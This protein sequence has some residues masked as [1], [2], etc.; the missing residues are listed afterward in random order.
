MTDASSQPRPPRVFLS[1]SHDSA[2]HENRVLSLA[3]RLR[4]EGVDARID[5]YDPAPP[6]GWPLWMD[7]EIQKADFVLLACTETYL[8]RVEGGDDPGKGL[9]VVWEST[10]IYNLLY[11]S[12]APV[13]KF[14]PILWDPESKAYIPSPLRGMTHYQVSIPGGYE[15]LYRHLTKQPRHLAPTLGCLT[16]L[17]AI[18]PQSYPP[19]PVPV[20][21]APSWAPPMTTVSVGACRQSSSV[22]GSRALTISRTR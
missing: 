2:E 21:D 22:S 3:N 9:G 12:D 4:R 11:V 17:P 20:V 6:K 8:R 16:S 5:Q 1:Y 13:Q 7:L 18:E 15:N 14:I 19:S 10:L